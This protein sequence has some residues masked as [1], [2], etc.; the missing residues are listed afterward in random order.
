MRVSFSVFCRNFS[1]LT[2]AD[3]KPRSGIEEACWIQKVGEDND[4]GEF[5]VVSSGFDWY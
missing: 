3:R 4:P 5:R 2:R 1:E